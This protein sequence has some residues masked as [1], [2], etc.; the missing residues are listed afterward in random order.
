MRTNV[1]A[2]LVIALGVSVDCSAPAT[3]PAPD[4]ILYDGKILTGHDAAPPVQAVAIANGRFSAVGSDA[5]IR[6]L[7]GERTRQ[8]DL[9]GRT[10][11]PGLW[12]AHNHQYSR[13]ES[14]SDVDLTNVSSIADIQAAVASRAKQVKPG[15]W[16]QGTRGWWEYRLADKRLP[17][18]WDLDKAAPNNPVAIPGPHYRI[19]N[20]MAF[21][22]SGVT[23]STKDPQGGEIWKDSNGEPNGLL[24]DRAG[25]LLKIPDERPS[26]EQELAN[27]SE[28][29]RRQLAVGLTAVREP[30]ITPQGVAA[31]RKL[32]ARGELK[33]RVDLWYRVDPLQPLDET[34]RYVKT[35][36]PIGTVWGD[37]MLRISGIKMGI[38]GAEQ[39]AFLREDYPG[40]PGYRGLQFL[41]TAQYAEVCRL[42]NRLGW[43]VTTHAVGDA[44]FDQVLDAYE[45]ANRDSSIVDKRWAVEHVFLVQ[46]D[47]YDRA[48]RLNLT[49]NSQYQH[50]SELGALILR[51]WGE[52]RANMSEPF[53][54]WMDRG[55]VLAGGSDGP[56]SYKAVPMLIL[57]GSITR[58]TLWGGRLGPEQGL[59]REQALKTLTINA[60]YAA[61]QEKIL[62]SIE[63]GKYADLVV[64]SDDYMTV[65]PAAIKDIRPIAVVVGGQL[66]AGALPG[67]TATN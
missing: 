12:D 61:F 37:G 15:E 32:L 2:A 4:L 24:M 52:R 67:A 57:W 33:Q 9:G 20:S 56:I 41:P 50:N 44:A 35:F 47:H 11:T 17:T 6:A 16:I 63:P 18:R 54:T 28:M 19:A 38:D 39:S 40:K 53:K 1:C 26:E 51:A 65:A 23:R 62:G 48:K 29:I 43:V 27:L 55:F 59:T 34:E 46:P 13:S 31:Y 66:V 5:E 22:V 3:R 58:D 45:A 30:G 10:V 42:L 49:I 25:Q 64:L 14:L 60:A 7:A 21:R 36:E 8:I